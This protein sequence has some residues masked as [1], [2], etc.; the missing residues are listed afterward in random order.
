M[1]VA[2]RTRTALAVPA[3]AVARASLTLIAAV[4]RGWKMGCVVLSGV[5]RLCAAQHRR[6]ICIAADLMGLVSVAWSAASAFAAGRTFAATRVFS[7]LVAITP[8][9]TL[10][11]GLSAI[12]CC[13]C[14]QA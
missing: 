1:A 13:A 4:W 6:V 8:G 2:I 14:A 9:R 11:A 12:A 5:Q 7:A 10:S 3:I